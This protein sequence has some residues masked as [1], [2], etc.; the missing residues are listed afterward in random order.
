LE[1]FENK[2]TVGGIFCNLTKAFDCV[3]HTILLSK[4]E[5]YGITGN[6]YNLMKSYLNDRYERAL[7][8]NTNSKFIF[9]S[10]KKPSQESHKAQF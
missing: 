7:I 3:N 8:K 2:F 6:A 4:L 1:A 10:G 9:L 5:F